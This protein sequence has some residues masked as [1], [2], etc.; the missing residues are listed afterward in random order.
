MNSLIR[1]LKAGK[2]HRT[3]LT[4]LNLQH[5]WWWRRWWWW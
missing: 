1:H 2:L 3:G 5:S 4:G